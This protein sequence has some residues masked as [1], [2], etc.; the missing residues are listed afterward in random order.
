MSEYNLAESIKKLG[1]LVPVLKDKFGN[2]IDGFHRL[3]INPYA[4]SLTLDWIDTPEKLE[5]ARLAVNYSRRTV[6]QDEMKQRIGFLAKQG[7][8]AKQ[9]S[10][11]TG[12]PESTV[13]KY[14]PSEEKDQTK[15]KAGQVGGIETGIKKSALALEQTVKTQDTTIQDASLHKASPKAF[16]AAEVRECERCHV[17]T[18]E[19]K[20]WHG[21]TL[22]SN[23]E[24]KA[25]LQPEAWDGYLKYQDRAKAKQVPESK[26][27]TTA[28]VQESWAHRKQAMSQGESKMDDAMLVKLQNSSEVR[29]L[30]WSVEF[31]KAYYAVVCV[32]DL[33]LTKDGKEV[34]CFW[35]G[36]DVHKNPERDEANRERAKDDLARSGVVAD[37]LAEPYKAY[38]DKETDRL[39][40]VVLERLRELEKWDEPK[41]KAKTEED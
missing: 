20:T 4:K 41:S 19:P 38:S 2:V 40:A 18:T 26:P 6:N 5:T 25:N 10:W 12:I 29:E 30:G 1:L 28:P 3:Q 34:M 9:V 8:K 15:V 21:H 23:C 24:E 17:N 27:K 37:V 22:C 33:S 16:D 31:Q 39:L 11:D 7:V 13:Y 14:Y 35:D 36:E 32:S